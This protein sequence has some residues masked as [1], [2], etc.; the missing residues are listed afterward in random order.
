[1]AK[2]EKLMRLFQ[3]IEIYSKQ[4]VLKAEFEVF[5]SDELQPVE[6]IEDLIEV[7]ESEMSYWE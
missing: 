4:G 3:L 1:M 7:M 5:A 2:N 6:T